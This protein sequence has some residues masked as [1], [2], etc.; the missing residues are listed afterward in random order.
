MHVTKAESP[1]HIPAKPVVVVRGALFFHSENFSIR[2]ASDKPEV[3]SC[4]R[5]G[6]VT[7]TFFIQAEASQPDK[8]IKGSRRRIHVDRFLQREPVFLAYSGKK[9]F[10]GLAQDRDGTPRTSILVR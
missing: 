10:L 4:C 5:R 8:Q 1:F 7:T 3:R 2:S 9:I 6:L